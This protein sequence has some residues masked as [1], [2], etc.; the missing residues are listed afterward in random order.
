M[1]LRMQ[2][3]IIRYEYDILKKI[4]ESS[5]VLNGYYIILYVQAHVVCGF[6]ISM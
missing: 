6:L 3:N 4:T 1:Y 5:R 2:T